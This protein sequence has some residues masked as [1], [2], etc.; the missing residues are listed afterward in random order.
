MVR[1]VYWTVCSETQM[2]NS[3]PPV[4][5]PSIALFGN[6]HWKHSQLRRGHTGAASACVLSCV[7][8]LCDPMDGGP[9][10]SSV[11]GISQPRILEWVAI[12]SSRGSSQLRWMP[13][14]TWEASSL[15]REIW[16]QRR[17]CE[18]EGGDQRGSSTSEAMPKMA[19]LP[20]KARGG[21]KHLLLHSPH[22]DPNLT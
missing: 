10:G 2:L 5:H 15:R 16:A 6:S 4:L 11:H 1:V 13:H 12:S 17:P 8:T 14:P 18:H 19:N 22:K 20:P 7:P 21:T 9:S 3:W